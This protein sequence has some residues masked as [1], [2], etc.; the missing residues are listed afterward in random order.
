MSQKN[1]TP[2]RKKMQESIGLKVGPEVI[3]TYRR[4]A[5]EPWYAIAE[6]VDNS[7][8]SYFDNK[9]ILD[10]QLKETV[11]SPYLYL[12]STTECKKN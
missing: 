3:T 11:T 1:H 7:T 12:W 4:L 6:F 9:E 2:D 5:Y 8:Q 10:G